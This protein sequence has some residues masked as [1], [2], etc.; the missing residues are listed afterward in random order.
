[1]EIPIQVYETS[2]HAPCCLN[3]ILEDKI[4]TGDAYIPGAK[5]VSKLPGGNKLIA[6]K[7][8]QFM[9]DFSLG[10]DLFPGHGEII[11]YFKYTVIF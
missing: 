3:Y 11:K 4:F 6:A 1:M 5:V 8:K 2:G 9:F 7:S 10:K